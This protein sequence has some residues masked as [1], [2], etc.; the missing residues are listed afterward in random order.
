MAKRRQVLA[1]MHLAPMQCKL[2][3]LWKAKCVSVRYGDTT[4]VVWRYT[5]LS[6][7][8]SDWLVPDATVSCPL[9]FSFWLPYALLFTFAEG[10]FP[11]MKEGKKIIPGF[12]KRRKTAWSLLQECIHLEQQ[13][14]L[15]G[16][17]KVWQNL[18]ARIL[19]LGRTFLISHLSLLPTATIPGS[20]CQSSVH[21]SPLLAST[22]QTAENFAESGLAKLWISGHC[23][24]ISAMAVRSSHFRT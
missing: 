11:E 10:V 12:G 3:S 14:L 18:W 7:S 5:Q 2:L 1:S 15:M 8:L 19:T 9:H 6:L 20:I 22:S 21:L 16:I 4:T 17:T 23:N 13:F 24:L